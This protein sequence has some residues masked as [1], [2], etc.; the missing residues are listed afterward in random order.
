MKPLKKIRIL[1]GKTKDLEALSNNYKIPL[2]QAK[3]NYKLIKI[4]KKK[5][6]QLH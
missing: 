6:I 2:V 4:K 5:Y 3:I 1:N